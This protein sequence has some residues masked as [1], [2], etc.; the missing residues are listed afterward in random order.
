LEIQEFMKG[1]AN[2]IEEVYSFESEEKP[3]P[4]QLMI[5][6]RTFPGMKLEPGE[7]V[8]DQHQPRPDGKVDG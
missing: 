6:S 3:A 5:R 8:E 7:R 2:G 1:A 4:N